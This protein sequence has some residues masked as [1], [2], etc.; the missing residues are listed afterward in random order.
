MVDEK[1]ATP[2]DP[3]TENPAG[4]PPPLRAAFLV[5]PGKVHAQNWMFLWF[6]VAYL[7]GA[8][9]PWSGRL[10]ADYLLKD[11]TIEQAANYHR[12]VGNRV[13][14]PSRPAPEQVIHVYPEGVG[15][16]QV[17]M[18]LLAIGLVITGIS[19]IWNRKLTLWPTLLAWLVAFVLLYFSVALKVDPNLI[20]V[21]RHMGMRHIGETF[22]ALF[23]NL[24]GLFNGKS[25]PE[26]DAILGR[27][28][29]GWYVT[30]ITEIFV[31]L[32]IVGSVVMGIVTAKGKDEGK[33][34]PA[35]KPGRR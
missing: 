14:D 22:G 13:A 2:A 34:A 15:I 5:W 20:D 3:G 35:R 21:V 16:A 17:L 6:G 9:L 19:N 29:V 18:L 26:M 8:L 24:G 32:F 25:T 11:G 31:I 27:V 33:P 1:L 10:E 12:L 7:I 23:S 4:G 30:M 28:G